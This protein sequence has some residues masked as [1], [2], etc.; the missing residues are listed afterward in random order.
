MFTKIYNMYK[1]ES[2][3]E[4]KYKKENVINELL[5]ISFKLKNLIKNNNKNIDEYRYLIDCKK[6]KNQELKELNYALRNIKNKKFEQTTNAQQFQFLPNSIELFKISNKYINEITFSKNEINNEIFGIYINIYY[7]FPDN[8][9]L[10]KQL[11]IPVENTEKS[12]NWLLKNIYFENIR[13]NLTKSN[14]K[15]KIEKTIDDKFKY[16]DFESYDILYIIRSI[17]NH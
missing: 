7:N 2:E 9:K 16:K 15:I 14:K 17:L 1:D 5:K 8:S 4:F 12:A 13:T 3:K 10:K 6:Y 11:Y